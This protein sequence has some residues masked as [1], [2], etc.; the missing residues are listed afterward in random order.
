MNQSANQSPLRYLLAYFCWAVSVVLVVLDL[1]VWRSSL[2]I[3]LGMTSWDRYLEHA[4]NQFGFLFLAIVGL[5]FIIFSEYFFRTG[6]EKNR[7]LARFFLVTLIAILMLTLAHLARLG[8]EIVL[9]FF[10]SATLLI[11]VAELVICALLF[12]LYRRALPG[13]K[14][15]DLDV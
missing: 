5:A 4:V 14:P 11:V 7:L 2:M 9:G 10:T 6:V 12:W 1:L 15:P 8:G 3:I 13:V